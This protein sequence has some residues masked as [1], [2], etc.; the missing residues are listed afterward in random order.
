MLTRRLYF[1][2]FGL[3]YLLAMLSLWGQV[4][5]LIGQQGLLPAHSFFKLVYERFG[6]TA[7]WMLPSLCWVSS[8]DLMLDLLCGVGTLLSL[9]LT[10]G[11]APRPVLLSLWAIYL[12]LCVAGQDFLSFQWDTLLLEMTVC[13]FFYAPRGLR[14]DW[15]IP[16]SPWTYWP[17]WVLAFKLMFLSGITKLLSGDSSW[18]DGTALAFHYYTQPIPSWPAWYASQ[19]PFG[20]NRLAL[21]M[22][23]V[24]EI[25]LPFLVFVGRR[26]R[27][28]F[29]MASMGIDGR[30]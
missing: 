21:L 3:V 19:L 11:L 9:L 23:F 16:S 28:V 20:I 30:D 18:I 4:H 7:Y 5:D 13:S 6:T 14:P 10:A 24:A 26:G 27:I 29:G 17:L 22:L 8:G 2:S 12:S 25:L 15:R 1:H